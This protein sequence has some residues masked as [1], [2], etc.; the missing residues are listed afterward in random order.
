[1]KH[2]PV[3]MLAAPLLLMFTVWSAY[4]AF[5]EDVKGMVKVGYLADYT[6]FDKDIITIPEDEIP[7]VESQMTIEG[8]KIVYQK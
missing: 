3:E 5:K 2:W 4:G 8:G 6:V 7:G 1:M